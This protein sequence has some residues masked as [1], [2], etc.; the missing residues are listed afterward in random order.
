MPKKPSSVGRAGVSESDWP[1]LYWRPGVGGQSW[2]SDDGA[3]RSQVNVSLV[4]GTGP[5][6]PRA[7]PSGMSLNPVVP[8]RPP[9]SCHMSFGILVPR[10][11]IQPGPLQWKQS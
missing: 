9:T 11:R 10:S 3:G 1:D 2:Y 8:P 5:T 7:L 4:P 6:C